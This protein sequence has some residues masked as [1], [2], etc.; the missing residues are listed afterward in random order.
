MKRLCEVKDL[1][2]LIMESDG[3]G[4]LTAK[5]LDDQGVVETCQVCLL[6]MML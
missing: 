4:S 3:K 1:T 2:G 5:R 6:E